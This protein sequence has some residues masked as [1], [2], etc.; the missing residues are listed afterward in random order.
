MN[1]GMRLHMKILHVGMKYNAVL[2]PIWFETQQ[3]SLT[4]SKSRE[5]GEWIGG[6]W[7]KS[8]DR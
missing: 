6:I 2:K 3:V 7:V 1:I 8:F 5:A 4:V